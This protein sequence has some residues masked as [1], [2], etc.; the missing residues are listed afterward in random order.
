LIEF[1]VV[2]RGDLVLS[3]IKKVQFRPES[4]RI[5]LTSPAFNFLNE[6]PGVK[7]AKAIGSIRIDIPTQQ[8]SH[9]HIH[10]SLIRLLDSLI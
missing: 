9:L 6:P 10:P 2:S 1:Q 5:D 7:E 3:G 4:D 8:V